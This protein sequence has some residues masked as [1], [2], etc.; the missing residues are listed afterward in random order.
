MC[1]LKGKEGWNGKK[2]GWVGCLSCQLQPPQDEEK[3]ERRD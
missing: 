1:V 3:V 2:E